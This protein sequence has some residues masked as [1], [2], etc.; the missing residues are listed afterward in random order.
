MAIEGYSSAD[1][2]ANDYPSLMD[3]LVRIRRSRFNWT[4]LMPAKDAIYQMETENDF[5]DQFSGRYMA[6]LWNEGPTV[7][8]IWELPDGGDM[9]LA[10]LYAKHD[11][12]HMVDTFTI[13][14]SQDLL[15]LAFTVE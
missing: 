5:M 4:H 3:A 1:F 15:V 6:R 9:S 14:P 7:L 12:P 2:H 10:K 8:E 11:I 13:E